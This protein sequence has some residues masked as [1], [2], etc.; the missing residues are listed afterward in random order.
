VKNN[1]DFDTGL[2]IVNRDILNNSTCNNYLLQFTVNYLLIFKASLPLTFFLKFNR[3][4]IAP[5]QTNTKRFPYKFSETNTTNQ[6]PAKLTNDSCTS[7]H[8]RG[9]NQPLWK[10]EFFDYE[11]NATTIAKTSSQ[12]SVNCPISQASHVGNMQ[13]PRFS[14]VP[15]NC[16][17][18]K[19]LVM[20]RVQVKGPDAV[21]RSHFDF[22]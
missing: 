20:P 7:K 1:R 19:S 4:V 16:N 12:E 18:F 17:I 2:K 10:N 11:E 8:S 5:F 14:L 9:Y 6:N 22:S 3:F 13:K 15:L 21:V